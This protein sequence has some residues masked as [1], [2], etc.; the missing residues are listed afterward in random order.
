M[1]PRSSVSEQVDKRRLGG[2]GSGLAQAQPVP[3][4]AGAEDQ[5]PPGPWVLRGCAPA[6]HTWLQA[7][8]PTVAGSIT[9][10]YM[11]HHLRLQ[12]PS[13]TVAGGQISVGDTV[14]RVGG[15]SVAAACPKDAVVVARPS[16]P[17]LPSLG[18]CGLQSGSP[19]AC[20]LQLGCMRLQP[21]CSPVAAMLHAVAARLQP[22]CS[23]VACGCSPV[24]CGLQV[25]SLAYGAVLDLVIGAPP[26]A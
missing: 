10:G 14:A 22:G 4:P 9:Y 6:Q 17:D 15:T 24:A 12:P 18:A 16:Q 7:P 26:L 3:R 5:R 21:G 13:P 8:L 23:H 11:I 1:A 2:S 19:L 25:R 20:G